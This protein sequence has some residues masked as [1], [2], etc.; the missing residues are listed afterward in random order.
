MKL[1]VFSD[2]HGNKSV[3]ETIIARNPDAD[4]L[5][6]LGDSGLQEDYLLQRDIVHVKGN[7][8]KDPGFAY[9]S[10]IQLSGHSIFLTHGHKYKVH[11]DVTKLVQHAIVNGHDI[12]MY[13]HTHSAFKKVINTV[14]VLNPGSCD[15]SR[16]GLPPSYLLVE[17]K[18][19]AILTTFKDVYTDQTIAI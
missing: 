12:A 11:K 3:V 9:D 5:I 13:G 8:R 18:E 15:T 4:Y 16:N 1:L 17:F 10:T 6:S 19:G 2:A 7:M 14:L